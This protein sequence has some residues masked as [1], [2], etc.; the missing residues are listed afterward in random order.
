V[1]QRGGSKRFLLEAVEAL[2]AGGGRVPEHLDRDVAP[3]PGVDG[4]VD[5]SMPPLPMKSRI[6]YGPRR[7]PGSIAI[8]VR[9]RADCNG[10]RGE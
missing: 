10:T 7:V 1:I 9:Y 8:A 4:T 2:A 6:S 3:Q 5:V